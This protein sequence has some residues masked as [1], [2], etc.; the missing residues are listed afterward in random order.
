[1]LIQ[2]KLNIVWYEAYITL[3]RY[4]FLAFTDNN[5]VALSAFMTSFNF[6]IFV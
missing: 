1:M 3:F 2:N 4:V 6:A 5:Y